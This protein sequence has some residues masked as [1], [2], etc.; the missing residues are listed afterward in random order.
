MK[1]DLPLVGGGSLLTL[2]LTTQVASLY[3][4][5][6]VTAMRL[7]FH[8]PRLNPSTGE[9]VFTNYA[10][11]IFVLPYF[12]LMIMT[13]GNYLALRSRISLSQL[14]ASS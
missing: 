2:A 5:D 4:N 13:F 9:L 3:M 7:I 12:L 6:G 14:S 1:L 11:A 8:L 10:L